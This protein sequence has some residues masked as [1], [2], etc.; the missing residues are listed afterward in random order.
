MKRKGKISLTI[1]GLVLILS[2]VLLTGCITKSPTSSTEATGTTTPVSPTTS[3]TTQLPYRTDCTLTLSSAPKIREMVELTFTVKVVRSDDR[4]QPSAGLIK[5]K[6]WMDTYWTNTKGS[7]SEAYTPVQIPAKEVMTESDFPWEG[8]YKDGLT[9]HGKIQ[10]PK[11]GIWSIRGRF[12]GE[13]WQAGAGSEVEVAVA[14]GTA[15]IMGTEEFKNGPLAYMANNSYQGGVLGPVIFPDPVSLGLDISKAP[16]P[17]E[18]VTLSWRVNSIIDIPD[19]SIQWFF[20][21]RLGDDV[22]KIPE[23]E[24]LSNADLSWKTDI[25]KDI[26]VVFSTTIKLPTE[27]DWD[28]TAEGKERTKIITGAVYSL[29]LSITST[30]SYF[31][32]VIRPPTIT[33]TATGRTTTIPRH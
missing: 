1:F 5:S 13:G 10:L 33:E 26:P 8:S 22:Q 24:L 3:D 29:K 23:T 18:E 32:W 7:Y 11:E 12:Y 15:A 4:Y 2:S 9:L 30:N 28:I 6:A 20:Y 14:D 17:G 16:R 21:R 19:F 25:K 27:G 31:G